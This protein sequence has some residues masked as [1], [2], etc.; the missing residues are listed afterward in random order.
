MYNI[1][2]NGVLVTIS[3]H[4]LRFYIKRQRMSLVIIVLYI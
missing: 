2:I 1:T 3:Q 4:Y